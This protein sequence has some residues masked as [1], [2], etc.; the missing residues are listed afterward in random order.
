MTDDDLDACAS[1]GMGRYY[2]RCRMKETRCVTRWGRRRRRGRGRGRWR[3]MTT[4]RSNVIKSERT[5][6]TVARSANGAFKSKE[7]L[8]SWVVQ[9]TLGSHDR[10]REIFYFFLILFFLF[11]FSF[12]PASTRG[13]H[14]AP[15]PITAPHCSTSTHCNCHGLWNLQPKQNTNTLLGKSEVNGPVR[16]RVE[17]RLI[18]I[19]ANIEFNFDRSVLLILRDRFAVC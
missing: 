16:A 12:Y 1:D 11:F 19:Y 15:S 13:H 2:S 14:T 5:T 6:V 9:N 4:R 17:W 10:P 3:R 18:F 8:S 7:N